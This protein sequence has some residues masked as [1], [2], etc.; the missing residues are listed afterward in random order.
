[1]YEIMNRFILLFAFSVGIC[2]H[3]HSQLPAYMK[4]QFYRNHARMGVGKPY[5][6]VLSPKCN[7][8]DHVFQ[9]IFDRAFRHIFFSEI[10]NRT[11]HYSICVRVYT[12]ASF[13]VTGLLSDVITHIIEHI[14]KSR[15]CVAG[16]VIG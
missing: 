1:M 2:I 3:G 4:E 16:V 9:N 14:L 7:I 5:S 13:S 10:V 6:M 15:Y 8:L 11:L 12:I